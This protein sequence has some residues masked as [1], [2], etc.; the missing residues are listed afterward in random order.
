MDEVS[1]SMEFI[2][3]R[4]KSMGNTHNSKGVLSTPSPMDIE[5]NHV[6]LVG[7]LGHFSL[8]E[9][10]FLE[11]IDLMSLATSFLPFS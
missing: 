4:K 9:T 7:D 3:L 11:G 2:R 6:G 10:L 5:R 8:I 1:Y